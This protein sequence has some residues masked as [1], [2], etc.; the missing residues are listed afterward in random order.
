VKRVLAVM[1]LFATVWLMLTCQDVPDPLTICVLGA[2]AR[3][4]VRN[5]PTRIVPTGP[6]VT[7]SVVPEIFPLNVA[8][9][10][11]TPFCVTLLML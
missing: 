11:Q 4:L 3:V 9:G 8:G 7:V 1:L 10:V 6:A 2:I 5:D